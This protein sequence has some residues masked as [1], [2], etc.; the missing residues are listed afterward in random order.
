MKLC[1]VCGNEVDVYR[2]DE[3]TGSYIPISKQKSERLQKKLDAA[4]DIEKL[5]EILAKN[6]ALVKKKLDAAMDMV[7]EYAPGMDHVQLENK[8]EGMK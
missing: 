8:I 5:A 6:H 2:A 4:P 3:G 7:R 1:E